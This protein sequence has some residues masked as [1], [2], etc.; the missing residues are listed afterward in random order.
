MAWK[1]FSKKTAY[2]TK[3]FEVIE[4]EL[5]LPNGKKRTYYTAER[6]PSVFIFPLTNEN[7]L[8]LVKQYRYMLGEKIIEA[9]AGFIDKGENTLT[10]AKRE[11]R[12]E[13]GLITENIVPLGKIHLAASVFKSEASLFLAR[14]LQVVEQD[15]DEG[16]EIEV[17]KISLDEAVA[18]I[19]AGEI[20]ESGTILGILLIDKLIRE[21]KI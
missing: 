3:L 13:A 8:Y 1:I 16:E 20:N 10:A 2:K 18:K 11:L 12:E 21:S 4:T 19:I 15:L 14:D 9:P 7:E 6:D 17:V 5:E